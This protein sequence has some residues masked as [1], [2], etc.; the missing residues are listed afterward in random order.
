MLGSLLSG[1]TEAPGDFFFPEGSEL[2]KLRVERP[3]EGAQPV[4]GGRQHGYRWGRGGD[5]VTGENGANGSGGVTEGTGM[6][7]ATGAMG[8]LGMVGGG[9]VG[10]EWGSWE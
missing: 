10:G 7:V 1:T 4:G 3:L 9:G 6:R 2:K 8:R 5:G